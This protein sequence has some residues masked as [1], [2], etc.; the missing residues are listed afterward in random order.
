ML[1]SFVFATSHSRLFPALFRLRA[2]RGSSA[3]SGFP[4]P[5]SMSHFHGLFA[6]VANK[7]LTALA[8]RPQPLYQQHLRDP[9]G[10]VAIKGLITP[11]DSALTRKSC[12][13]SFICNTS[14]KHGGGG[15]MVN[16]KYEFKSRMV[17]PDARTLLELTDRPVASR[18]PANP[19]QTACRLLSNRQ[20]VFGGKMIFQNWGAGDRNST[21]RSEPS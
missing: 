19:G 14:K 5:L 21:G 10:C 4:Q 12:P 16:Q 13:N 7:E 8:S 3:E 17:L 15:V 18:T 20:L 11:L 2:F 6:S 1:F 9:L